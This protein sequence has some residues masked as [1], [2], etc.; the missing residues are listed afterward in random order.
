MANSKILMVL[1]LAALIVAIQVNNVQ[2]EDTQTRKEDVENK[3]GWYAEYLSS[4]H[5]VICES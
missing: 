4:S 2:S 5:L 3:K 1:L